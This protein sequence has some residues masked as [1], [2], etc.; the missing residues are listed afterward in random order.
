MFILSLFGI[1]FDSPD[2]DSDWLVLIGVAVFFAVVGIFVFLFNLFR[3]GKN[4][5]I[6]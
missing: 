1:D 4:K 6:L 2:I 5:K 3:K